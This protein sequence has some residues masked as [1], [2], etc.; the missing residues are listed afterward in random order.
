MAQSIN[1]QFLQKPVG[2]RDNIAFSFTKFLRFFADTFFSDRYGHP[3]MVLETVAAVPSMVAGA[4]LHLSM[5]PG[6]GW[7]KTLLDE[8]EN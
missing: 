3:A 4:L 5:Q 7:I 8:A 2:L 1:L 6:N